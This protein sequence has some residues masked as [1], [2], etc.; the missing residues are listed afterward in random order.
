MWMCMH[1]Y[2][3]GCTYTPM[4]V[5]KNICLTSTVGNIVKTSVE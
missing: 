3:H 4:V 1:I 2:M 5:C